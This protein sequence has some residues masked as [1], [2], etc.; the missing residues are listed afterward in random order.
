VKRVLLVVGGVM[1]ILAA[2]IHVAMFFGLSKAPQMP[3]GIK[4]LLYIFNAAVLTVVLF[5]TYVSLFRRRELIETPMGHAVCWFAALFYV[6]RGLM[7]ALVHGPNPMDLG[8]M[9]AVAALYAIAATPAWPRRVTSVVP[10]V[11]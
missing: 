7:G 8:I 5:F 11:A 10:S 1:Q 9:L 2:A 4:P 3:E 6:Q